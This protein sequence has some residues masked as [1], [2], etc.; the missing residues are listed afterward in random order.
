MSPILDVT[1]LDTRFFTRTG[2]VT[3][4]NRLSFAINSR[5]T[6]AIV[7]ESGCGKSTVALSLL[8]LVPT[9]P[10]R[11]VGGKI[12]L[13]GDNLLTLDEPAMR[14][15]R[16]N[17]ISMIFQEPMTSLNPVFTVGDQIAEAI[18]QHKIVTR[19][20]AFARSIELLD[21]VGIPEP[22]RIAREYPHRLSGGMRQRAMIAMAVSCN[23]LLLIA[24][25]PTTALDVTIQAQV[26]RLLN[27]L[28]QE[29]GM[30][31]L[32]ITHDLGV[33]AEMADRVIVMYAGLKMEEAT[34]DDLFE[35][36]LHPYTQGLLRAIPR[37]SDMSHF[38]TSYLSEIPGSVPHIG[39]A[40]TTCPFVDRCPEA[41]PICR[42]S[43]PDVIAIRNS[44]TVA[45]IVRQRLKE[46]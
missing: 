35:Q 22:S 9:P 37:I 43:V 44:H 28:K 46:I 32:L 40:F 11:I 31:I 10:G 6:L 39:E 42:R 8:R 19:R 30:S 7:G 3:A 5:E 18:R 12:L 23:P 24:D 14:Q 29:M 27:R 15:V 13:S 17:S 25:E 34:V 2:T 45:C 26:L 4:V 21:L 38:R 36:P 16:G 33:V 20:T 41:E 1:N